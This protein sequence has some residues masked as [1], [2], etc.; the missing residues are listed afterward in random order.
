MKKDKRFYLGI[1]IS[2]PFFDASLLIVDAGTKQEVQPE[3]F[4]NDAAGLRLFERWLKNYSVSYDSNSL[5]VIENTGIYH[6]PVWKFCSTRQLPIHIGNAAHIKWSQGITR[7]KSDRIDSSRLC[8]YGYRHREELQC[9]AAL[10]PVFLKLKDLM[11][12]RIRLL[13]QLTGL[14]SYLQELKKVSDKETAQLLQ[15]CNKAAL[16][17]FKKS[18]R[19]IDDEIKKLISQDPSL[20]KNYRLL[21]TVP[22][23]GHW[24][25]VYLICC[26]H[27]FGNGISGKQL[28]CYAGVAPFEHSSGISIRGRN[29]V[30][31]MANKDLKKLLHLAAMATIKYYD[32]FKRYYNRK[33]EEGKHS[34]CVLNAIRNKI[35]LRAAAVVN[36]Q[37]PYV[38]YSTIAA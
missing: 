9:T 33:K 19:Q 28:A 13:Q 10:N 35:L 25:A 21:Q 36:N 2:K 4:A 20:Y 17:G 26:T 15:R 37:Q 32:E 31:K 24:I 6:R 38:N 22:G 3:R 29:R 34:M 18:L 12:N 8:A 5:V 23:I 16:E 7:G 27:N 30:H 11:T 14:R 1:D